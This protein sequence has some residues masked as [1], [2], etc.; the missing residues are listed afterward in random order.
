MSICGW[1]G[2]KALTPGPQA[3]SA[4]S[5]LVAAVIDR[6]S[7]P[8][9]AETTV[10][11]STS[12][13]PDQVDTRAA[14]AWNEEKPS[15][16]SRLKSVVQPKAKADR[17]V[18]MSASESNR[19]DSPKVDADRP[20]ILRQ[21][22]QSPNIPGKPQP[23]PKPTHD[24]PE[25]TTVIAAGKPVDSIVAKGKPVTK[26]PTTQ[27]SSKAPTT[28]PASPRSARAEDYPTGLTLTGVMYS[29]T[30]RRAIIS[31]SVVYE[32]DKIKGVKVVKILPDSVEIEANGFRFLLGTGPKPVWLK[33]SQ[34]PPPK[35]KKADNASA[36]TDSH[37]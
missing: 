18:V 22:E 12:A 36:N 31:G 11:D 4:K 15:G 16:N 26:A 7:P 20:D 14:D 28:Q 30:S 32:G 34:V 8:P 23:T 10:P 29:K 21:I 9:K 3:A 25:K 1:A 35:D 5:A 33:A 17:A 6:N 37:E 19:I 24:S 2:F 27:P 13:E